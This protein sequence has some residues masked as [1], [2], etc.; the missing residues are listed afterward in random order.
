MLGTTTIPDW[1]HTYVPAVAALIAGAVVRGLFVS[2][3]LKELREK[4]ELTTTMLG[5]VKEEAKAAKVDA[6]MIAKAA[7]VDAEMIAKTAKEDAE[8][9]AKTAKEDAEKIARATK[10]DT[11][12]IVNARLQHLDSKARVTAEA[13]ARRVLAT[14]NVRD[15]K[16]LRLHTY[17]C[18]WSPLFSFSP[19]RFLVACR[20]VG[21]D[22]AD[23]PVRR[24]RGGEA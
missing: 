2:S 23:R 16:T 20:I 10:E 21:Q 17:V 15:C 6:E 9:I 5:I 12:S 19:N 14:Y 24:G 8:K 7:K 22:G 11:L 4:I 1:V 13:E 3:E 18:G